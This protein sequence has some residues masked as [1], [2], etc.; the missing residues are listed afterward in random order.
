MSDQGVANL[1]LMSML[2]LLPFALGTMLFGRSRGNRRVLKWARGLAILTIV[3]STAY[4]V[5]G[6]VYLLLA[7][8]KPGHEP[9]ADPAAVVDY[10]TV[11]LPIGIGALLA[12]AGI[13]VGVIRARHRLG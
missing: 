13:L 6:A 4:D 2:M 10:P 3:L 1:V 8:P 7:E 9:W 12:A 11:F 5:A